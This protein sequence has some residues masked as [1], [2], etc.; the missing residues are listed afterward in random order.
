MDPAI[1]GALPVSE[2]DRRLHAFGSADQVALPVAAGTCSGSLTS[3]VL[4]LDAGE[5]RGER[6]CCCAYERAGGWEAGHES[7]EELLCTLL[8]IR[9][10]N[11]TLQRLIHVQ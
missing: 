8:M 9:Y 7:S 10:S 6:F 4:R 1:A 5:E 3:L 2:T 11:N